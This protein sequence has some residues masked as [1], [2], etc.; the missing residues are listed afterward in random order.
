MISSCFLEPWPLPASSPAL[1][2]V[3]QSSYAERAPQ[4]S[5]YFH[6]CESGLERG[7]S[8]SVGVPPDCL[9]P[10]AWNSTWH[11]AWPATVARPVLM[12]GACNLSPRC[13]QFRLFAYP[14]PSNSGACLGDAPSCQPCLWGR[15]PASLPQSLSAAGGVTGAP[16]G[17]GS[18]CDP[19]YLDVRALGAQ[20]ACLAWSGHAECCFLHCSPVLWPPEE[21]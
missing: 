20:R 10:C 13:L 21:R 8:L 2:Y 11:A 16:R 17:R 15:F 19:C 3:P 4:V 6:L 18:G 7:L 14:A 5:L 1:V 9:S 12:G